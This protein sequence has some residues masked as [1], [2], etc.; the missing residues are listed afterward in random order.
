MNRAVPLAFL[1]FSLITRSLAAPFMAIG[2]G[3][4]LFVTGTVGVRADDNIFLNG[5]KEDDFIFD[6]N[7]GL[8]LTFGKNAQTKGSLTAA[9]AFS[10]YADHSNL[11]TSLFSSNFTTRYDDGKMKLGLNLG[12]SEL[13]QNAPDIRGLTRRD[14]FS[15]S[16]NGELEVSQLTSVGGGVQFSHENYKRRSYNDSDTFTV[17][18]NFYY[19]WTPKID[20]SAGYRYRDY[21]VTGIGQDSQDHFF[22]I[23]ARGEFSPKLTGTFGVGIA[24]RERSGVSPTTG[25]R[26]GDDSTLGLDASFSYEVSPKTSLELGA[27]NDFGTSPQGAQQKNF[28]LNGSV[29]TKLTEEWSVN[30]GVSYRRID[31]Y[32]RQDDYWEANLGAAFTLSANVRIVGAYTYRNYISE[33]PGSDFT[34]N[35]FSIAANLR[36]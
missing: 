29:M 15:T 27:S 9:V 3:A 4:E 35:V 21:E 31:Y 7:P 32:T 6:I 25:G 8:D 30:G 26:N 10:N 36:Y 14:I 34:N 18:L 16:G 23:G 33:L 13:N 12:F 20:V 1:A 11:N 24:T 17:P 19:K 5:A 22:S 28:T 2:D